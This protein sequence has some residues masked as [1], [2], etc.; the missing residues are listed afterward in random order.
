[1][2][3][4][5]NK[6]NLD[7][8]IISL[9]DDNTKIANT[10]KRKGVQSKFC[11][12]IPPKRI[13]NCKSNRVSCFSNLAKQTLNH[14]NKLNNEDISRFLAQSGQVFLNLAQ[15]T[16]SSSNEGMNKLYDVVYLV[17]IN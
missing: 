7:I 8:N 6:S 9:V 1:M 16:N 11:S 14:V 17:A 5:E 2:E 12:C 4:R 10:R 3:N 15:I 13:R